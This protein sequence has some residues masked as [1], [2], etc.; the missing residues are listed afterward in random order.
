MPSFKKG[1]CIAPLYTSGP[2]A[3]TGDGSRIVT[4]VGERVLFTD[5]STGT[6][7]TQFAT[8]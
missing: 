4:C 5:I 7:I 8:V 6:E 1:R 2:V 3:V